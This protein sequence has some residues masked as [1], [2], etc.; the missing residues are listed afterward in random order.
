MVLEV[1]VLVLVFEVQVLGSVL[2][3]VTPL[4]WVLAWDAA[5]FGVLPLPVP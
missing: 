2:E 4:A 5:R 1:L 3:P